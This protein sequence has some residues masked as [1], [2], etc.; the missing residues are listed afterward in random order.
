MARSSCCFWHWPRVQAAK[1]GFRVESFHPAVFVMVVD[2]M[3]PIVILVQII[4]AML[5]IVNVNVIK[6]TRKLRNGVDN[7]DSKRWGN[8]YAKK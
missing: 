2:P 8:L 5:V 1:N 4:V 7:Q 3:T 6:M